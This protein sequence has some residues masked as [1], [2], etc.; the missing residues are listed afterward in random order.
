M[1]TS[2]KVSVNARWVQAVLGFALTLRPHVGPHLDSNNTMATITQLAANRE[3]ATKSTGPTTTEGK[4]T[5]SRNATRHGLLSSRLLLEDE[6]GAEYQEVMDGLIAALRPVGTLELALVE[7]MA[8][9]L[10]RQRRL[11]RAE[12]AGIELTRRAEVAV[13]REE[14]GFALG[15]TL[16]HPVT[17]AEVQPLTPADLQWIA[18]IAT[19]PREHDAL[20]DTPLPHAEALAA[21]APALY[22]ELQDHAY[23]EETTVIE[24]LSRFEGGVRQWIAETLTCYRTEFELLQ[25]RAAVLAMAELVKSHRSA[26]I[27]QELL[28]RYQGSVDNELHKAIRALR[29]AQLWRLRTLDVAGDVVGG[30]VGA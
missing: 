10:W 16:S 19:L 27:D 13:N 25:R 17:M 22:K 11:V 28:T 26:P 20:G 5:S 30:V 6:D 9:A 1:L 14:I 12:T 8:I 2:A 29:E 7:R 21:V 24:L 23:L 15:R 4:A 18:D 3:N